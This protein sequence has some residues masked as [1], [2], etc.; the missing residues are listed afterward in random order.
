[1]SAI[2]MSRT[3]KL[4]I[5]FELC[6]FLYSSQINKPKT[7]ANDVKLEESKGFDT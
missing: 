4:G 1:M 7:G 2:H 3:C 6:L 5:Q